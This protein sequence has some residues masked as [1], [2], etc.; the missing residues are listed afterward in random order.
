MTDKIDLQVANDSILPLAH[1]L[2]VHDWLVHES[3]ETVFICF[4]SVIINTSPFLPR[5]HTYEITLM[6]TRGIS[7]ALISNMFVNIQ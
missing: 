6:S 5:V 4:P 7:N 3:W 1:L 2:M